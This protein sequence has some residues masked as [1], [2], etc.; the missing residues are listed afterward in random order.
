MR[1]NCADILSK[2]I[3]LIIKLWKSQKILNC[4][5]IFVEFIKIDKAYYQNLYIEKLQNEI[6]TNKQHFYKKQLNK[7]N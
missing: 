1:L 5:K 4:G 7:G 6:Y 2:Q 3:K